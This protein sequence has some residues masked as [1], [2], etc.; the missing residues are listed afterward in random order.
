MPSIT[1]RDGVN[2]EIVSANPHASTGLGKYLKGQSAALLAGVDV[3]GQ[4][5]TPLRLANV[6]ESGL[7]LSWSGDVALGESGTALTIEAGAKA[8][9]GVLN[10]TGMEVF[11]STFVGEPVKVAAGRALVSFAIRPSLA[12]GLK[13]QV[14]ALSFGFSAGGSVD[15]A[16]FHPFDLM[17]PEISV[18]DACRT[19]LE[20]YAVLNKADRP[21]A[22]AGSP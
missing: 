4:L 7:G 3:A 16:Y 6:G 19:V 10:R 14:G 11:D 1:I 9:I 8:V 21:P 20:Q 12:A 2:A 5:R 15:L 22:H 18:A 17:G 13:K